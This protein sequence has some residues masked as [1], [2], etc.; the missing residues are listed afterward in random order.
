[1]QRDL[2]LRAVPN[3]LPHD[4]MGV[5]KGHPLLD[6]V[7]RQFSGKD[8]P[9]LEGVRQHVPTDSQPLNQFGGDGETLQHSFHGVKKKF[10]VFLQ[11]SIVAQG[12]PFERGH[13]RQQMS[14]HAPGFSANQFGYVRVFFLGHHA[15]ARTEAVRQFHEGKF[16]G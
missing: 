5:S 9:R 2:V 1:M 4:A 8:K 14:V 16:L 6:E 10:F 13:D 11:V 7:V 12:K 15:A 3:Q